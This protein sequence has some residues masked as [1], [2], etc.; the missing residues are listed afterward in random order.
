MI[1]NRPD[2]H[3][4]NIYIDRKGYVVC[5]DRFSDRAYRITEEDKSKYEVLSNRS[6]ISLLSA[7]VIYASSKNVFISAAVPVLLYILLS[8]VFYRGFLP[9][10]SES[11]GFKITKKNKPF[12]HF[13]KTRTRTQFIVAVIALAAAEIIICIL[14][15]QVSTLDSKHMYQTLSLLTAGGICFFIWCISQKKK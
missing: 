7:V 5:Y 3:G 8:V 2:I 10:L 13:L 12:E 4:I 14:M 9:S 1:V 6:A 15:N 11:A